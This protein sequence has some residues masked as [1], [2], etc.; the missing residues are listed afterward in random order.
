MSGAWVVTA[1]PTQTTVQTTVTD[2]I[3]A[4]VETQPVSIVTGI[5]GPPGLNVKL[6]YDEIDYPNPVTTS[7]KPYGAVLLR[8]F[9]GL[10]CRDTD[11][12]EAVW[13]NGDVIMLVY[14]T[15]EP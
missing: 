9:N 6:A 11:T 3:I 14:L 10:L 4:V 13:D 5:Q 2:V 7:K 8:Y 1:H 15:L 12:P